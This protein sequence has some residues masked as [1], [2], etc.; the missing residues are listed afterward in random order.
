MVHVAVAGGTG[1]VGRTLV[2]AIV[3][4]GRH[5]V[6]VMSRKVR[7]GEGIGA[8]FSAMPLIHDQETHVFSQQSAV[9]LLITDYS[10]VDA[11]ARI[12]SQNK[13][14]TVISTLSGLTPDVAEAELRLIRGAAASTTVKRFAPSEFG[15][16][17]DQD[18]EYVMSLRPRLISPP[19]SMRLTPGKTCPFGME[20]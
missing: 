11:I 15:F 20:A 4:T 19:L 12:L 6:F 13:I 2:E 18:D 1:S 17:Y 9:K 5:E 3:E 14:H 10:S 16:D 7:L 8:T